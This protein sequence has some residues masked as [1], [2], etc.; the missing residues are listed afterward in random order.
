MTDAVD[1][2]AGDGSR[3]AEVT[4]ADRAVAF[5]LFERVAGEVADALPRLAFFAPE[6][7]LDLPTDRSRVTALRIQVPTGHPLH[8]RSVRVETTSGE[9][10]AATARVRTSDARE[11]AGPQGGSEAPPGAPADAEGRTG[12]AVRAEA[13][14]T[15]P[16]WVELRFAR[17]VRI[18]R[19][20]L[21]NLATPQ[22]RHARGLT[23]TTRAVLGRRR[24]VHDGGADLARMRRLAAPVREA[25][26]TNPLVAALELSFMRTLRGDYVLARDAYH[27]ADGL[28]DEDRLRYV[29]A[30][31]AHLLP[32]RQRMWTIHGPTHSFVYWSTEEKV[33]H[34]R[35]AVEIID[36]LRDVAPFVSFGFG[37]AL[38]IVRDHDLIPHDDDLDLVVAFEQSAAGTLADALATVRAR[39][40]DAGFTVEGNF[41]AH[42]KA[43][44][45]GRKLVD[46]F[47]GLFEG[48][49]IAW[50]PGRRGALTR[51]MI[52]PAQERT[53][54][55]VTCPVP[56]RPEDYLA[57]VYGP[58]WGTPH[59]GFAHTW[60]RDQY[61]D[62]LGSPGPTTP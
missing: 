29:A 9:E 12:R 34:L 2:L 22:A 1:T 42:V 37:S 3:A 6:G 20:V 46:V 59:P 57:E 25:A 40:L 23:V 50:Y 43:A 47:V 45:P 27:A 14:P 36:A 48:D 38:G 54:H 55:G 51:D 5:D 60:D 52:V 10:V 18:G 62:I 53:I 24:V 39:L 31:N 44:R 15:A 30:L 35:E 4:D 56:A 32:S 33:R 8:L 13:S 17:P 61:A 16:S 41:S 19:I 28:T 58:D 21:D 7:R 26:A 49:S 11:P